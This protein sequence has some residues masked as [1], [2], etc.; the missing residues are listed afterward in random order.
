MESDTHA[1]PYDVV[2]E[3]A[4]SLGVEAIG[5]GTSRCLLVS[6]C[7]DSVFSRG[8][9]NGPQQALPGKPR[10]PPVLQGQCK[11]HPLNLENTLGMRAA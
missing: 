7:G 11:S 2:T 5:Q 9:P 6:G 8:P 3:V 10:L 1:S 4:P